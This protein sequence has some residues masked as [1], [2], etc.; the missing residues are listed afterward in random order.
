MFHPEGYEWIIYVLS[1]MSIMLLGSL[2]GNTKDKFKNKILLIKKICL[3]V[4]VLTLM[5]WIITFPYVSSYY[6]FNDDSNFSS[7]ISAEK[8]ADYITENHNRIV[9]LERELGETKK[10]LKEV[11]GRLQLFLQFLMYG[12]IFFASNWIFNSNGKASEE[13]RDNLSLNS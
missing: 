11:S 13:N 9:S 1:F 8:Q 12:M 10:E 3:G 7:T 4:F 5:Y 2:S 6:N